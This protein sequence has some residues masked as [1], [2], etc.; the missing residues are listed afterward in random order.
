MTADWYERLLASGLLDVLAPYQP[1]V[2]GAHP[3]D[4][5]GPDTPVEIVCRAVD[6]PA[7]ARVMERAFGDADGF[8]LHGGRLDDE[9]AVFAEFALDG[10]RLE[11][12][13][14]PEHVH[15]RLGAATLG[16]DRVLAQSPPAARNRL[17]A[18]V[19]GGD[20]WLDAALAQFDL[21]RVAIESLASANPALVARVMG[22]RRPGPAVRDYVIAVTLGVVAE[23]LIVAAGSARGSQEY[24]GLML[25]LEAA[26]LGTLFGARLGIVASLVPLA[27]MGAVIASSIT[28]GSEACTPD[29]GQQTVSYL[30][31]GILVAAAAGTAGAVRD[32]YFPRAA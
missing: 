12:A 27:G 1:A 6:L 31:V 21:S 3:L 28:V 9:D 8:S 13:A 30:F 17:A 18:A 16:I 23:T 22:I 7:F 19:A 14:Q 5:A 26:V 11:V 29:C 25:M 4:V 20:D 15:R 32:R 24:T 2:V 10:L